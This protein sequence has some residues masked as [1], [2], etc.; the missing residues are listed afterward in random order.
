MVYVQC[1][2]CSINAYQILKGLLLSSVLVWSLIFKTI[3]LLSLSSCNHTQL[4]MMI[5]QP[6]CST[7]HHFSLRR[8]IYEIYTK[9]KGCMVLSDLTPS[10]VS[11]LSSFSG[12]YERPISMS[13]PDL[14]QI[15]SMSEL[16]H[17]MI[18]H[19]YQ[20]QHKTIVNY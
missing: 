12:W 1:I 14:T 9:Y 6:L 18:L 5:K 11:S 3:V 7:L 8:V 17:C 19:E 15:A 10:G 13:N 2:V 16:G 20:P 4:I